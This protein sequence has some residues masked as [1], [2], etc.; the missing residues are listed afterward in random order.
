MYDR[1]PAPEPLRTVEDFGNS[2]RFLHDEDAFADLDGTRG[3]LRDREWHEAA[4]A[5]DD[6]AR[7]ELVRAREAVRAHL[8]G[9]DSAA[10]NDFAA[11]LLAS[12]RWQDGAPVI[13]VR[14]GSAVDGVIGRVL[15]VLL[16]EDLA[17][18]AGRLKVCRAPDCRWLF[19]D[20]SP[21]NNSTWCSMDICGARHKMRTYR[22]RRA[23]RA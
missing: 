19:Y 13:L 9:E 7:R 11:R 18:R 14:A 15:A 8:A 12:P 10:V 1:P 17:G 16:T 2:A 6:A 20:R 23:N 4:V 21:A 22:S 3:W 5:L